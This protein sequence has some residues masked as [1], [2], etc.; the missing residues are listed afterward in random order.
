A[1]AFAASGKYVGF[2]A[3]LLA[4]PLL[5]FAKSE[6]LPLTRGRLRK[7]G[8]AF[9]IALAVINYTFFIHPDTLFRSL[10]HEVVGA[11]GGHHGLTRSVPHAEYVK[12]FQ[13]DTT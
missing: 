7:F 1:C 13:L 8:A 4:L 11:V 3:P 6:D 2:I 9:G 12:T 5:V 10:F